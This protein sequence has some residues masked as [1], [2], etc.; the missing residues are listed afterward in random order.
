MGSNRERRIA[1]LG[2]RGEDGGVEGTRNII[3]GH[4]KMNQR[5]RSLIC[6]SDSHSSPE[7]LLLS[8]E[9][10]ILSSTGGKGRFKSLNSFIVVVFMDLRF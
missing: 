2:I 6:P 9:N 7:L 3:R 8:G 4:N 10:I 5:V 1:C